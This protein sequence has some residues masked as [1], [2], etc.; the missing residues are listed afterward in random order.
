MMLE[1]GKFT[2]KTLEGKSYK[3]L[4]CDSVEGEDN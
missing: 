1:D 4:A 2:W 3:V